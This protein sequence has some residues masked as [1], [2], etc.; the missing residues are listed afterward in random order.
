MYKD[1]SILLYYD[2]TNKKNPKIE[3]ISGIVF[4]FEQR[5]IKNIDIKIYT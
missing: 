2:F 4:K 5:R 1:K 3:Y